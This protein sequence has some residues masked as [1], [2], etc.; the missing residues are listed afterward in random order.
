MGFY[1]LIRCNQAYLAILIRHNKPQSTLHIIF[2][3]AVIVE[4]NNDFLRI[5]HTPTHTYLRSDLMLISA[6]YP[7]IHYDGFQGS[8]CGVYHT[9]ASATT[10]YLALRKVGCDIGFALKQPSLGIKNNVIQIIHFTSI[11]PIFPIL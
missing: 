8:T 9:M 4:M 10:L 5:C 7:K 3:C 2:Q 1:V 11:F 6:F